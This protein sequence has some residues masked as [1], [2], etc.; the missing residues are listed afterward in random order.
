MKDNI[1]LIGMPGVGKST[2]GVVLAKALGYNAIQCYGAVN[3]RGGLSTHSWV[4]IDGRVYDPDFQ[5]EV[6]R[7]GFNIAYGQ[8]GTLTYHKYGTMGE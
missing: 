1:V 4:E 7:N 8:R 3:V 6:G 2:V 5:V